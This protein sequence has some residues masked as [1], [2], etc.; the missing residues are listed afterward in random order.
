M[1]SPH[2]FAHAPTYT[3]DAKGYTVH[4][5]GLI[6]MHAPSAAQAT[7]ADSSLELE[8]AKPPSGW[9]RKKQDDGANPS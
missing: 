3:Q 5:S 8:E 6:V 4:Y 9:R 7:Q 2:V 1:R